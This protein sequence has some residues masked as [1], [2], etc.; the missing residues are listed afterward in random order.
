[1]LDPVFLMVIAKLLGKDVPPNLFTTN[2]IILSVA[3]AI[4]I[5]TTLGFGIGENTTRVGA[6]GMVGITSVGMGTGDGA[7]MRVHWA[8]KVRSKMKL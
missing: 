8:H 4:T 2:L 3:V 6:G 5:G 1:M 7:G